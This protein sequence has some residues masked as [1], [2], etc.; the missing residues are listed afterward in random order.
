MKHEDL[1]ECIAYLCLEQKKLQ[2]EME[3]L[4]EYEDMFDWLDE[5]SGYILRTE[6]AER[7][8]APTEEES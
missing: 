4:A 1:L 3:R 8:I 6:Y 7:E 2:A 5:R